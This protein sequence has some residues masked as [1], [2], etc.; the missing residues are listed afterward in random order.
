MTD[1][2]PDVLESVARV[3]CSKQGIDPDERVASS[4]SLA[5]TY[6]TEQARA[7]LSAVLANMREPSE[8]M[9]H[10]YHRCPDHAANARWQAMLDQFERE[11]SGDD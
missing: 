6:K 10:V 2:Q 8:T 1:K 3:I 4:G 5:W 11:A 9:V 7:A